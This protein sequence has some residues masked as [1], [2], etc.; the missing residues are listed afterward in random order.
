LKSQVGDLPDPVSVQKALGGMDKLYLL[1]GVA[2]DE[3]T[4]G[5]IAYDLAKKLKVRHVVYH[6]VFKVDQFKD[7]PHFAA[8][9][10]IEAALRECRHPVYNHPSQLFY[11][12]R[13]VA[14]RT[15]DGRGRL[16][17]A[18]RNTGNL[19]RGYP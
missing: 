13:S 10:A 17:H 5:L 14:E 8:K 19:R 4:Q 12:K 6:S 7:V 11:S 18:F 15:A 1:N 2:A 3:L 9:I 16:S